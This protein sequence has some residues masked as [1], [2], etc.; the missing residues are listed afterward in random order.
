MEQDTVLALVVV[1]GPVAV[2]V[3]A[4]AGALWLYRWTQRSGAIR[5]GDFS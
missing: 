2:S 3:L 4:A 5:A 1:A